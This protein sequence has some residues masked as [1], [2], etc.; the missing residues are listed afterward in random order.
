M[1]TDDKPRY[2]LVDNRITFG[3]SSWGPTPSKTGQPKVVGLLHGKQT[4]PEHRKQLRELIALA[5]KAL[6]EVEITAEEPPVHI[7]AT[8]STD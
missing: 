8:V 1:V 7:D 2:H 4:K 5:N 3:Q 6:D